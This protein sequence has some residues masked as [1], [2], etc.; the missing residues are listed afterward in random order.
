MI[1]W[2]LN[3]DIYHDNV[4]CRRPAPATPE[5]DD[6]EEEFYYNE[7]E[8]PVARAA[9]CK[10]ADKS[11]VIQPVAKPVLCDHMDMARPP[12]ENPEY[13]SG[14]KS[15]AP[16]TMT[17][18]ISTGSQGGQVTQWTADTSRASVVVDKAATLTTAAAAPA[19]A[20]AA[21]GLPRAVP[22]AIP[23]TT[24]AIASSQHV[25]AGTGVRGCKYQPQ[26]QFLFCSCPETG[27]TQWR[28]QYIV[29]L[30]IVIIT[31]T[32]KIYPAVAQALHQL[33]Q[34]SSKETPRR[35][36]EVPEGVRDGAPRAVVHTMQVEEGLHQVRGGSLELGPRE[37]C[38][39]GLQIKT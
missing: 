20:A 3:S 11:L 14:A 21:T 29:F 10:A 6:H 32:W 31:V 5:E 17:T 33:T 24:F 8:V 26:Y 30:I 7:V 1:V 15:P 18:I 2:T 37:I 4:W 23:I 25:S 34:E 35:R 19:P 36:Q 12:H 9:L 13:G 27:G 16:A 28:L 38:N 39:L 22:I